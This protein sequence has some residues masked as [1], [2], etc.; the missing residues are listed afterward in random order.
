MAQLDSDSRKKLKD[1]DFAIPESRA[2][3]TSDRAHAINALARVTQY[4]SEEERDKVRR[5]VCSKFPDLPSCKVDKYKA[6]LG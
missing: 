4:G 2:Y 5:N 6:P 1:S 3:P